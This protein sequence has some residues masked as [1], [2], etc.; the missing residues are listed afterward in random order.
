MLVNASIAV[1][2]HPRAFK[3]LCLYSSMSGQGVK[4][5]KILFTVDDYVLPATSSLPPG[6]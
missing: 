5:E 6:R 3:E 2:A 1:V 4:R